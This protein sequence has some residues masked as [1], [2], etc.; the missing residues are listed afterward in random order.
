MEYVDY[1][2][3]QRQRCQGGIV[4]TNNS[5]KLNVGGLAAI[6]NITS[7]P[8]SKRTPRQY[9]Y[10]AAC[11]TALGHQPSRWYSYQDWRT[12]GPVKFLAERG[13]EFTPVRDIRPVERSWYDGCGRNETHWRETQP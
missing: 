11:L 7:I 9:A 3:K 12:G 13:I 1:D 8:P 10:L 2:K 4:T 6:R 5:G